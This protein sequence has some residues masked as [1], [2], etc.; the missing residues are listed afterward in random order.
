[1][2][3]SRNWPVPAADDALQPSSSPA[4]LEAIVTKLYGLENNGHNGLQVFEDIVDDLL[5]EARAGP[6]ANV[7]LEP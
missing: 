4:R 2:V 1:L 5:A 3:H 7:N 6:S